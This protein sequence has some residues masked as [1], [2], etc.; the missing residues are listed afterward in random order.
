MHLGQPLTPD[1]LRLMFTPEFGMFIAPGCNGIR[2]SVTMALIAIFAGYVYRFRWYNNAVLLTGAV[3]LGY[4]FNLVRLC[5]LVLYYIVALH[6]PWLQNR[7]EM[8]DYI[9]GGALFLCATFLL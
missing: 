4:F 6:F 7:A 5:T 3:L 1:H 2:G 8:A 9:L